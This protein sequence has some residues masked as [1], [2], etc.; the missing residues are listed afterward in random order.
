MKLTLLLI[1][2]NV[3][4]F[5]YT[6]QN[7]DYYIEKFGFSVKSIQEGRYYTP[8][9][10]MFLHANL[11]HLITNMFAL[12]V[13]GGSIESK[14]GGKKYL[15]VY[16]LA[17]VIGTLSAFVPIFG[18]SNKALFVGA[19]GAISGLIGFGI[20]VNPGSLV[21]FPF[22]IPIP[23]IIASAIY[24]LSTLPLLFS[25]TGI[26]YPAH[27]FGILTGVVFGLLFGQKRIKRLLLFIIVL[28]LTMIIPVII[29]TILEK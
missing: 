14:A 27:L 24:L 19:S 3:L 29:K 25:N 28:I 12:L 5:L 20:F 9:T 21:S 26:A 2:V 11:L 18:Y 17:G 13:L 10:S 16:F 23:F 1:L 22:I 7:L 4:V 6:S 15:L 8:L